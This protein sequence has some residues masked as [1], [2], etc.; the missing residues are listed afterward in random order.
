[1]I[2]LDTN[3]L[4]ALMRTEPDS[5]VVSWLDRQSPES[6]WT[7]AV[8][9]LEVKFGLELLA[10]GRRRQHLESAFAQMLRQDLQ[11]RV[12]PFDQAAAEEAARL[13]ARRQRNGRSV[14]F[15][16]TEIAGIVLARRA[17]LA[18][19]NR[20]HFEDLEIDLVDPWSG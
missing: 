13:A 6:I 1:M 14:D 5:A 15:R 17:T 4:S 11:D 16:D 9:V 7:T 10:E 12:L 18:T 8:T 19:R 3:V 2:V 20:R